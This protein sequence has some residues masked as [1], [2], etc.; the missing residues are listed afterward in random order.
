[1]LA[2]CRAFTGMEEVREGGSGGLGVHETCLMVDI[3]S[4]LWGILS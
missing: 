3:K 4:L 2:F 1:M